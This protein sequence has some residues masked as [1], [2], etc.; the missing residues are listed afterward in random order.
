MDY[1]DSEEYRIRAK[2]TN[3]AH[4]IKPA[5]IRLMAKENLILHA[6]NFRL[7]HFTILDALAYHKRH[8]RKSPNI[9]PMRR[10]DLEKF[11]RDTGRVTAKANF[12][13][14]FVKVQGKL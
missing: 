14:S 8:H 1:H 11:L 6:G 3:S 7:S 5:I 13:E 9:L 10:R 12:I 2:P 4:L